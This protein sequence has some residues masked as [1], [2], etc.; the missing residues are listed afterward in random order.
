MIQ[1][2]RPEYCDS[3]TVTPMTVGNIRDR[4]KD[5]DL[6]VTVTAIPFTPDPAPGKCG[7]NGHVHPGTGLALDAHE[8]P[9]SNP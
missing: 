6:A 1:V 3:R 9:R 2:K 7:F 8:P 5:Q 4:P